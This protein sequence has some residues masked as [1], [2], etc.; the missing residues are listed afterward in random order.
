MVLE[1]Y[2]H[3]VTTNVHGTHFLDTRITIVMKSP[4]VDSA[5]EKYT[6][7]V[8]DRD[9]VGATTI[10]HKVNEHSWAKQPELLAQVRAKIAKC[11]RLAFR[12][13]RQAGDS[14]LSFSAALGKSVDQTVAHEWN[15]LADSL[16]DIKPAISKDGEVTSYLAELICYPYLAVVK[17]CSQLPY[18][19]FVHDH[20]AVRVLSALH[21]ELHPEFGKLKPATSAVLTL[22][23]LHEILGWVL[24]LERQRGLSQSRAMLQ[25][26]AKSKLYQSLTGRIWYDDSTTST[27]VNDESLPWVRDVPV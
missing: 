6:M 8:T 4:V 12:D 3:C 25:Q 7:Y 27:L 18:E 22:D 19:G 10:G 14:F 26:L 5:S 15:H 16:M 1:S 2:D 11:W 9:A 21:A 20:A 17:F 13:E 24:D 23:A